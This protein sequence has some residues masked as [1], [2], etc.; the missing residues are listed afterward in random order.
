MM[1]GRLLSFWDGIFSGA[2][3]N[4]QGVLLFFFGNIWLG[5]ILPQFPCIFRQGGLQ[6]FAWENGG[7]Q[8]NVW[9]WLGVCYFLK[10]LDIPLN[11]QQPK[12]EKTD[13]ALSTKMGKKNQH[14][15][16]LRPLFHVRFSVR[17]R[18]SWGSYLPGLL[19]S[20]GCFLPYKG[21]R[22]NIQEKPSSLLGWKGWTGYYFAKFLFQ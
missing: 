18:E 4:F 12:T 21:W 5:L 13:R 7:G 20:K 22:K 9:K 16:S 14:L 1:V 10:F 6:K 8:K 17:F 11:E 15:H 19:E 3:L 2:M